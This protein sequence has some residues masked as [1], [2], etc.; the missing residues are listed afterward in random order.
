MI[1]IDLQGPQGNAFFLL[2]TAKRL[3]KQIG[4]DYKTVESEMTSGDYD[5]LLEVFEDYFGMYVTFENYPGE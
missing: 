5:H 2:A 3:S 4:Y 1:T